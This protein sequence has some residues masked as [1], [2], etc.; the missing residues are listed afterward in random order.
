MLKHNPKVQEN[1]AF[2]H[3]FCVNVKKA[4]E[5]FFTA[6]VTVYILQCRIK[7]ERS[8]CASS[9]GLCAGSLAA[10]ALLRNRDSAIGANTKICSDALKCYYAGL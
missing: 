2:L 8:I 5:R 4:S 7:Y 3:L 10:A 1:L 6:K 9:F